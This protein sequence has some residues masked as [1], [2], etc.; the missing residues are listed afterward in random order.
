MAVGLVLGIWAY[1]HISKLNFKVTKLPFGLKI[2]KKKTQKS[3]RENAKSRL[4]SGQLFPVV[5]R[6]L[7]GVK[8]WPCNFLVCRMESNQSIINNPVIPFLACTQRTLSYNRDSHSYHVQWCSTHDRQEFET[9]S[10]VLDER[11]ACGALTEWSAVHLYQRTNSAVY[12]ESDETVNKHS[13]PG[14]LGSRVTN[15]SGFSLF[16]RQ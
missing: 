6:Q 3:H 9:A 1:Y 10:V 12:R 14:N 5:Y 16:C 11:I 8:T 13:E 15:T 2:Y 7:Q 4:W